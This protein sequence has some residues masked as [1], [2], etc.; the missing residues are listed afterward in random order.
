M[1]R[2]PRSPAVSSGTAEPLPGDG[3]LRQEGFDL[4]EVPRMQHKAPRP[5]P[6]EVG[7]DGGGGGTQMSADRYRV[8]TKRRGGDVGAAGAHLTSG[9]PWPVTSQRLLVNKQSSC[10]RG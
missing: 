3:R 8:G 2:P 6:D 9:R 10:R 5:P 1:R 7:G 4:S